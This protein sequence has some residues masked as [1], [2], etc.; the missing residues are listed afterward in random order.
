MTTAGQHDATDERNSQHRLARSNRE[1]AGNRS[2]ELEA[3]ASMAVRSV[4]QDG[5][6]TG[7]SGVVQPQAQDVFAAGDETLDYFGVQRRAAVVIG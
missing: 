2:L 6:A 3:M 1:R 4:H 7:S 5:S